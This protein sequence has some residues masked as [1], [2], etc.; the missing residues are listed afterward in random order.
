MLFGGHVR[1]PEDIDFLQALEFDF[2]EVIIRD[3]ASRAVWSESNVRSPGN[4]GFF[5]LAH[6]PHEGPP[7]DPKNLWNTYVPALIETTDIAH[8]MNINLLTIHMW[9]DHR[10]VKRSV[11]EEKKNALRQVIDFGRQ[12]NVSVSLENLSESATDLE[13]VLAVIP[14]LVL[15]LDVGHGQLLAETNTSFEI[16]ERLSPFIRHIHLHDNRGGKGVEDDLHLPIG[17]GIIDFHGI[18]GSLKH[19]G[20]DGTMTLELERDWLA[21]G[22]RTVQRLLDSL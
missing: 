12:R 15:T 2:G 20:Y 16:L 19:R 4:E 11:I 14:D 18:L 3:K 9:V 17:D 5:L 8:R 1:H 13:A 10:F 6:G 21:E 22:R 7:N